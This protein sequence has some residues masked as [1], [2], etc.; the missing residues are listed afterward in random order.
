MR[1]FLRWLFA[2]PPAV[3][4]VWRSTVVVETAYEVVDVRHGTV[5]LRGLPAGFIEFPVSIRD[6]RSC[7]RETT[8]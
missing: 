2:T 1:N 8:A 3:R 6:L 7:Y 5:W 4:S